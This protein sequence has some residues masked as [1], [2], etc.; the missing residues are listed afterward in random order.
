MEFQTPWF[1]PQ[2]PA[3]FQAIARFDL[4]EKRVNGIE[5]NLRIAAINIERG[6]THGY[7]IA[8]G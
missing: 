5:V 6:M 4:Q 8:N 7:A 1:S 2:M 3:R